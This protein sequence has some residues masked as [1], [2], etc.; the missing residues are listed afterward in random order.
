VIEQR[1]SF[2]DALLSGLL[3]G[4]PLSPRTLKRIVQALSTTPPL[5][6]VDR[7]LD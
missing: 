5:D 1:P 6:G 3:A 4:R 2:E 7:L